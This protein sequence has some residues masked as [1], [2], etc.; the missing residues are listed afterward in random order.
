MAQSATPHRVAQS[1]RTACC[2]RH[3][4]GLQPGRR[5]AMQEVAHIP[6]PRRRLVASERCPEQRI[7]SAARQQASQSAP[8]L[9]C[10]HQ[11][12]QPCNTT[13]VAS[14]PVCCCCDE[15]PVT[16][17]AVAALADTLILPAALY[18]HVKQPAARSSNA[19]CQ[20]VAL[21]LP[22]KSSTLS[23][24]PHAF[25][26]GNG[27]SSDVSRLVTADSSS[28]GAAQ[29]CSQQQQQ[30]RQDGMSNTANLNH[31]V[32]EVLGSMLI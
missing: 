14:P 5:Y 12:E 2:L 13:M 21:C 27:F 3:C 16:K 25:F 1:M 31:N 20:L 23:M 18:E 22:M 9:N 10:N 15:Y 29:T 32:T 8:K 4:S 17:A 28:S 24:M 26:A 6:V 30:R 19:C 11:Y 7:P